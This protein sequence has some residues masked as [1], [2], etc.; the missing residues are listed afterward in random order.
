MGGLKVALLLGLIMVGIANAIPA[1]LYLALIVAVIIGLS[2]I[3]EWLVRLSGGD[4]ES[5]ADDTAR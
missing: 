1:M 3:A 4:S 2:A 5:T